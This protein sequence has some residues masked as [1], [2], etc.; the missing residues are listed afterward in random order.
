MFE[1]VEEKISAVPTE[2]MVGVISPAVKSGRVLSSE[3]EALAPPFDPGQVQVQEV[4]PL[5]SLVLAAGEVQ[6]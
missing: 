2:V 5:T 1:M 4:A 6:L 3:Q